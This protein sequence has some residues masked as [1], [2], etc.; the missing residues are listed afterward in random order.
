MQIPNLFRLFPVNLIYF[1]SGESMT[2]TSPALP[3]LTSPG[4]PILLSHDQSS[5]LVRISAAGQVVG[6]V[7]S[8]LLISSVGR[9]KTIL[10]MIALFIGQC[11]LLFFTMDA[12]YLYAGKFLGG[13]AVGMTVTSLPIYVAEISEV[14]ACVQVSETVSQCLTQRC[15]LRVT[16]RSGWL[17]LNY[18]PCFMFTASPLDAGSFLS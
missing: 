17:I 2:W 7:L 12:V 15:L 4:A 14:R 3:E 11:V 13:M 16:C 6:P 8:G 5:I 10:V 1:L 18:C 9:K